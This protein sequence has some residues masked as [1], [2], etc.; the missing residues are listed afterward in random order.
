MID[1]ISILLA[2][3]IPGIIWVFV[4]WITIPHTSTS[5]SKFVQFFLFGVISVGGVVYFDRIFP[6]FYSS[7]LPVTSDIGAVSLNFLRTAP[8]EEVMKFLSF[9]LMSSLLI[10]RSGH[11]SS[12]L[13]YGAVLGLGFA[14]IENI[15]YG[16]VYGYNVALMRSL[17]SSIMHV[18]NGII[19]SW[20]YAMGQIRSTWSRNRMDLIFRKFP[21][22]KAI[23]YSMS[24][25]FCCIM[26]HGYYNYIIFIE[27]PSGNTIFL[28]FFIVVLTWA[29]ARNSQI[30]NS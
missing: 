9:F 28:L 23:S 6:G 15:G 13:A 24:G 7:V 22:F 10:G 30:G 27:S 17:T 5:F 1:Y 20:F 8:L 4:I 25:L 14:V 3:L 2:T 29:M 21:V 16:V 11:P 18:G 26:I 19:L 12:Y